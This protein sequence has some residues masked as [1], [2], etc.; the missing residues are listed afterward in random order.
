MRSPMKWPVSGPVAVQG[1]GGP[2]VRAHLHQLERD[3]GPA[4]DLVGELPGGFL[5][6]GGERVVQRAVVH[7]PRVRRGR[8]RSSRPGAAA[9]GIA[10]RR[11]GRNASGVAAGL[12]GGDGERD[13]GGLAAGAGGAEPLGAVDA[14]R[15]DDRDERAA[16]LRQRVLDAR[17]DLGERLAGDDALLLE[18][19]QAQRE[20]ARARCP[21]ASARARRSA[22][23]R[24]RGR[25]S[26]AA[27]TCRRRC[28]RSGRRDNR[29]S[30]R[31]CSL[32]QDFTN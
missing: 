13:L 5:D 29:S 3:L 22:S 15:L 4:G 9:R 24:R 16:L 31:G 19:A 11:A 1:R 10:I 23:G 26:R 6:E 32:P 8:R 20:R 25:G 7:E 2:G 12:G 21:R 14:H 28:R 18:R 27:S 30:A 17:R